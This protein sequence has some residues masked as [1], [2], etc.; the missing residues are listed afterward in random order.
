MTDP[1]FDI[2]DKVTLVSGGSRGIGK[3]MAR[4]FAERGARVIIT[5]RDEQTLSAA[6]EEISTPDCRV[7]PLV[8]DVADV[9]TIRKGVE[10]VHA[11]HGRIDV[12]L[13]VAG[14]NIRQPSLEFTEEQFDFVLNINLKGA[15]F[16]AQEVG[17]RMVEQGSGSIINVDSLNTYA[18]VKNVLPYAM[19]KNGVVMMTRT[20]P[21]LQRLIASF[22][23]CTSS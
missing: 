7:E 15:F 17:R 2:R 21:C 16:M 10:Q 3:A 6:A 1:L 4:G 19:S 22:R 9:E 12:L 18:P 23:S 13:N 14:V 5:G 20:S 11:T 8:C